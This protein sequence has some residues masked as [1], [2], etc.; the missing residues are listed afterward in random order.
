MMNYVNYDKQVV[1]KRHVKLTGWPNGINFI[2]PSNMMCIDDVRSLLHALRTKKCQWVRLSTS[3]AIE[4]MEDIERRRVAGEEVGRKRKE[5]SDKG[6]KRRG[7]RTWE[8]EEEE[9]SNHPSSSRGAKGKHAAG[10]RRI[11]SKA[12]VL[13]SSDEDEDD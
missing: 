8:I 12:V 2:P 3:E 10:R 5:R 13:S 11:T 6:K 7:Q 4:H 9:Q 1:Q